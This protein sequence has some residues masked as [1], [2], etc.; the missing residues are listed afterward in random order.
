[1]LTI[2]GLCF[3]NTATGAAGHH[4]PVLAALSYGVAG[5]ASFAALQM[6]ERLRRAQ[7]LARAAWRIAA[8]VVFGGGVWSMHFIAMLAYRSPLAISYS[9]ELTVLSGLIAITV[10]WIGL[11][12]FEQTITLGRLALSGGVIGTGVLAMH[13]TGMM[14]LQ[15]A[16]QVVYRPTLFLLSAVTA[17]AAATVAL[18]LAYRLQEVWQ[19]IVAAA[20]MAVA[21]CGMHFVG[22]AGTV[23]VADPTLAAPERVISPEALAVAV[24][25]GVVLLMVCALVCAFFDRRMEERAQAQ[26]ARLRALNESLEARVAERTADLTVAI[27]ELENANQR[28]ESANLAKSEFLAAMSHEIRTPLNGIL[29][30]VQAL[31]RD[32]PTEAQTARLAVIRECS[33]TLL[34]VLNDVLDLSKIEAG[35][36]ELEAR[37]VDI[38]ELVMGAH[39]A[40]TE[41]ASRRGISFNLRVEPGAEGVY[42][43]DSVRL[44]QILYNLISNALKF[45]EGGEVLVS[46]SRPGER[47]R[48]AVRDTGIGIELARLPALFDKFTQADNSTTRRF[49]GTG[50]GLSICRDLVRLMGGEI[51]VESELGRGSTFTVELPLP[52]AAAAASAMREPQQAG[53]DVQLGR[54]K[55]LAAEDN[56]VNQLVLKALLADADISL[57]IVDDGLAAVEAWEREAWDL[58]LMDIHMPRLDGLAATQA[59]RAREAELGRAATPIIALTANAMAHQVEQYLA[60]GMTGFVGKPIDVTDLFRAME[61]ALKE[62]DLDGE[63]VAA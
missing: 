30:M 18:F 63:S 1:M 37:E 23:I 34:A 40:F 36:L 28:A 22:M 4:D 31:T 10:V 9:L 32:Q 2:L 7:G 52:R 17:L 21:I 58:V 47:L 25:A 54:L 62:S 50:L 14:G 48:I 61:S 16:G 49:G 51:R 43:G 19:R 6:A 12:L 55:V 45:T 35:K 41:Q 26:A 24:T 8:A 56:P 60:A 33:E 59:I 39:A 20:V 27:A 11:Q 15:V 57:S 5:L 53:E 38:H 42:V 13:Y 3:S 46:I 44:R 29:G